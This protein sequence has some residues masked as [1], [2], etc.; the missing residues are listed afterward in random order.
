M[1]KIPTFMMG[2]SDQR[3]FSEEEIQAVGSESAVHGLEFA[4]PIFNWLNS[5]KFAKAFPA[6]RESQLRAALVQSTFA[7]WDDKQVK[8][9]N[10]GGREYLIYQLDRND[11]EALLVNK[12]ATEILQNPTVAG[13]TRGMRNGDRKVARGFASS[14]SGVIGEVRGLVRNPIKLAFAIAISLIPGIREGQAAK[15]I[16]LFAVKK[17]VSSIV[18]KK[19]ALAQ[20]AF[21][22]AA[23]GRRM[24]TDVVDPPAW[25]QPGVSRV[26]DFQPSVKK[27]P[28]RAETVQEAIVGVLADQ[29]DGKDFASMSIDEIAAALNADAG[30]RLGITR[31]QEPV[32]LRDVEVFLE[33]LAEAGVIELDRKRGVTRYRLSE[34]L[35]GVFQADLAQ[36][37]QELGVVAANLDGGRDA[38]RGFRF[39]FGGG[40][41][42]R[43]G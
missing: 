5:G 9:T 31:K 14:A 3:L 35:Q 11:P 38:G 37:D 29:S 28:S 10:V 16:G 25:F 42:S 32:P 15:A 2:N 39:G 41:Q 6:L 27:A 22:G 26:A 20:A 21:T 30:K 43:A 1:P 18:P 23:G 34:D 4:L 40:G 19:T 7:L 33:E 13:W 8:L 12:V 24:R 17:L 36:V